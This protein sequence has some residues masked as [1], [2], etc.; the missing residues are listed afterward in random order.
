MRGYAQIAASWFGR[1][2]DLRPVGWDRFRE[3]TS[4]E[5]ADT[6]WEH[7]MRNHYVSIDKARS[8]I[9]YAPGYE[10]D[11]AILESVRWLIDHDEL[12]VATPLTA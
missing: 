10:P 12:D 6:S 3:V 8:R 9:G 7:L 11:A 4:A 2:A 5:H 1:E